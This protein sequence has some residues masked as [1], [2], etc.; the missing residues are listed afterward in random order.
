M[1]I[2]PH[3]R[4]KREKPE[5]LAV[6]EHHNRVRSMDFMADQLVDGRS[7][8][9]LNILDDFNREGLAIEVYF[10]LP[11][12]PVVRML[13]WLIQWRGKPDAI[14]VDNSPEYINGTL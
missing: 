11:A 3:Q 7:F 10:S 13:N 4:L 1:R 2:K 8:I 9:T 6:P 14:R 5:P 12:E